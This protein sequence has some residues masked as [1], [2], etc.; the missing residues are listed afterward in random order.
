MINHP[1]FPS[2]LIMNNRDQFTATAVIN[3]CLNI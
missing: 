1:S 2:Q 3:L